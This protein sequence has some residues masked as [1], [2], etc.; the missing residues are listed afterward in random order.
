MLISEF[1]FVGWVIF[2]LYP[3]PPPTPLVSVSSVFWPKWPGV[4]VT[5]ESSGVVS[6]Y[7]SEVFLACVASRVLDATLASGIPSTSVAW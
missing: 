6:I 2:G 3:S 4:L 7:L 1:I 5:S